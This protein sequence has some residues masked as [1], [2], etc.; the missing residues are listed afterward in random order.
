MLFYI[1]N[2]SSYY[3][4]LALQ[5]LDYR[6]YALIPCNMFVVRWKSVDEALLITLGRLKL[7]RIELLSIFQARV[8]FCFFLLVFFLMGIDMQEFLN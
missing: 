1:F 8:N 7:M 5:F 4:V 2:E 6:T 3:Y